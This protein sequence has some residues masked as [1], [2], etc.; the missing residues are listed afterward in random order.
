MMKKIIWVQKLSFKELVYFLS[1][2]VFGQV[3]VRY[4]WHNVSKTSKN[5]LDLLR[6]LGLQSKLVPVILPG[7]RKDADGSTIF[8]Q[9]YR[10]MRSSMDILTQKH[11]K[12]YPEWFKKMTAS[13]LFNWT[14]NP[15]YCIEMVKTELPK[16]PE[17]SHEIY[18]SCYPITGI[19]RANYSQEKFAIKGLYYFKDLKRAVSP[20]LYLFKMVA[21]KIFGF[22]KN[23]TNIKDIRPAVWVEY[24]APNN[25]CSLWSPYV[26]PDGFDLVYYL[27]RPD[28]PLTDAAREKSQKDG[29]YFID[30]HNLFT[31]SKFKIR[32][33]A[34]I[35]RYPLKPDLSA[36]FWVNGL[37]LRFN[38]LYALYRSIYERYKVKVL[39]QHQD[40]LWVQQVQSKAVEDAG[41]IMIGFHWS[42]INGFPMPFYLA[43]HQVYFA[44]G[45]I[46]RD[47]VEANGNT[48]RHILPSGLWITGTDGCNGVELAPGIDFTLAVID[49]DVRHDIWQTPETL[50]RFYLSIIKLLDGN[51]SWAAIIKSKNFMI[52]G[53]RELPEGDSI[54][55]RLAALEKEKRVIIL[56][57]VCNPQA[58]SSKADLTVSY[59]F[60]TGG[61]LPG[62]HGYR[63]VMW[64]VAGWLKQPLYQDKG[65]KILFSTLDE[66]E[67]AIYSYYNGRKDIGDFS[68]WSLS[69]NYFNDFLGPQRVGRFIQN[70]MDDVIETESAKTSLEMAVNRY[71]AENNIGKE[72]YQ[73][74]YV[75]KNP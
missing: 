35:F 22:K 52:E 14:D 55:D 37:S 69:V 50:S 54:A 30:S 51:K 11:F 45:K 53:F 64:D 15:F 40:T 34:R 7:D 26:K 28:T 13:Y 2:A 17:A 44:W 63:T 24:Y 56:D 62:V 41:G 36:P 6:S 3:E 70:F 25:F 21:Y 43:P 16:F 75:W 18:V 32:E 20:F 4:D 65:Q 38:A 71:M 27:D 59:G 72:F 23:E 33:I 9:I 57:P 42:W 66:I 12:A 31:L 1:L 68:K 49:G 19:V 10:N 5:I 60:Q 58:A 67:E 48:C 74:E 47:F 39:I 8:Y 61:I 29:F 46:I 73:T